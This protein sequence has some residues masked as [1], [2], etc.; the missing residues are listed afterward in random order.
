MEGRGG[1]GQAAISQQF[2]IP[3]RGQNPFSGKASL[4]SASFAASLCQPP[5]F[6]RKWLGFTEILPALFPPR[7][8]P[9]GVHGLL[10]SSSLSLF[11]WER[12][13]EGGQP[14]A[15]QST[16]MAEGNPTPAR[17]AHH[18][19]LLAHGS[20]PL[21]TTIPAQGPLSGQPRVG[22]VGLDS[23]F[24]PLPPAG[25]AAPQTGRGD[26]AGPSSQDTKS[27]RKGIGS[28]S[29]PSPKE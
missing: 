13:S 22:F 5:P 28:P 14:S 7:W 25:V 21:P 2:P 8:G 1:A 23:P 11:G 17:H 15:A 24:A 12:L 16:P 26:V 3:S 9:K 19:A 10:L 18:Q 6:L 4:Q 29:P 27:G 20:G